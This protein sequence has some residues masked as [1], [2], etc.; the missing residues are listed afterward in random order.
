VTSKEI[1]EKARQRIADKDCWSQN[2]ARDGERVCASQAVFDAGG[3]RKEILILNEA[4]QSLGKFAFAVSLNDKTDH[5]TVIQMFD[6]AI[7]SA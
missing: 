2:R 7:Q 5:Q 1:L 6:L 3:G 4:A